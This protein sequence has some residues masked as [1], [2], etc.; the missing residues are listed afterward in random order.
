MSNFSKTA[1][2]VGVVIPCYKVKSHILDVL[3]RIGPEVTAIYV[4]DDKCPDGSGDFVA[5]NASDLRIKVVRNPVNTGVGGA[6]MAGYR[7]GLADGMDVLVKLDGDGQMD[8]ALIPQLVEPIILGEADYT[9][10][11]RFYT[12]EALEGMPMLRVIGNAGLSFLTK[13]ST[14]YWDILD[15]TN[16]FTAI[17]AR[18]AALLPFEK[19]ANRYFFES[20]MLFRLGTVRAVVVDIPMYA[21]Y[22]D[23]T[24]HLDAGAAFATFGWLNLKNACKRVFYAYFLRGFSFASFCFV[25][26]FI[27]LVFGLIF[28]GLSWISYGV[29]GVEAPTGTVMLAVLPAIVGFQLLLFFF[30]ADVASVPVRAI[31]RTL[32]NR[33]RKALKPFVLNK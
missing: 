21:F 22:G 26:G 15:P 28:G 7:E 24:S 16:G 30:S 25:F 1:A 23:E 32:A 3:K 27:L 33:P 31:H 9:K 19:I 11:N 5:E 17:D 12:P 8:G 6:V 4:V 10:G 20:D 18:V 29:A 14:G 13:L 2:S